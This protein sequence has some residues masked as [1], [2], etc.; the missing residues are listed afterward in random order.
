M[1]RVGSQPWTRNGGFAL[2]PPTHR[3]AIALSVK[4]AEARSMLKVIETKNDIAGC[5]AKVKAAVRKITS[6]HRR[7]LVGFPSGTFEADIHY[8]KSLDFWVA[9]ENWG[10]RF[11]NACGIGYPFAHGSPAP[12]LEINPPTEGINR[13]T[14]GRVRQGHRG[15]PLPGAL[16]QGGRRYQGRLAHEPA[17]LLPSPRAR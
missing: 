11:C 2:D 16:R 6:E 12:H 13:R 8:M 1:E 15:Q 10:D 5:E 17:C 14:A 7:H 3:T 4:T 9:L